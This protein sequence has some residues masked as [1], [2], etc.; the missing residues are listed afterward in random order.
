MQEQ[1]GSFGPR[2]IQSLFKAPNIYV[3]ATKSGKL[4]INEL[5]I[6]FKEIYFPAVGDK[7]VLF[8]DSWNTY[9]DRDLI[10]GVTPEGKNVEILTIPPNTTSLAQPLDKY[11]FRY[12]LSLSLSLSLSNLCIF[13]IDKIRYV[14]KQ[15]IFV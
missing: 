15:I 3:T 13:S 8:I 9:K 6:W 2:V 14:C 12:I 5:K 1:S 10:K 4:T 7:S 11:G